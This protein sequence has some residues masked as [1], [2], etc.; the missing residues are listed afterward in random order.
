[1]TG[2]LLPPAAIGI[3]GGGQL[4]MM[5]VREAQRM[6]YRTV[7]WD[8]DPACPA[9]RL[10]DRHLAA[11]YGDLSRT[12]EFLAATDVV[13]YEFEHIDRTVVEAL[14]ART[15]VRPDS[16][17]L[18][19]SCHRRD[20]KAELRR[21][22]FPVVRHAVADTP[23]SL[24]AGIAA[25]GLPA[26]VKT[27]TAGYDGKGQT[28]LLTPVQVETW[29]SSIGTAPAEYVVEEFL[30]LACEISVIVARS[31]SGAVIT[32]PPGR[33][34]HRE[35][36]LH[37]TTLPAEVDPALLRDAEECARAVAAAFDLRGVLCVEM[38]VTATGH[39]VVNE[40]APRPHNSG[41]YSLDACSISQFEACLR[42]VCD[43]PLP[44]PR[45]LTPCIMVNLLGK[46]L[47]RAKLT[48]LL[49]VEGAKLHLYGKTR[50]EPR[51]KMGH[52]TV[53]GSTPAETAVR[54]ARVAKLIG[55]PL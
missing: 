34:V 46:H 19:V 14:E 23:D 45:L 41:H 42:A 36:I 35:N 48:D 29:L 47:Q 25:I 40:L 26:V 2:P 18:A 50:V 28:V 11:P 9:A 32:F 13:T 31:P 49:A 38:F 27:A 21:H 4:G 44:Q 43:L 54:A 20:E 30:D 52:V 3:I 51:R 37:T 33:N 6:G 39:L 24:R 7:V 1:M 17:L 15:A 10:A 22:G 8:P 53:I 55:E 16:R 5:L 12:G